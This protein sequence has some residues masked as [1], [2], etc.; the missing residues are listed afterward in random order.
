MSRELFGAMGALLDDRE[1][2]LT[3]A[4]IGAVHQRMD[5]GAGLDSLLA[6]KGSGFAERTTQEYGRIVEVPV[7]VHAL[8]AW[9]AQ[10]RTWQEKNGAP[11][12]WQQVRSQF[13]ALVSAADHL[14]FRID[15]AGVSDDSDA[16]RVD[17]PWLARTLGTP[18]LDAHGVC[19]AQPVPARTLEWS[20]P[21]RIAVPRE[22][23][24]SQFRAS[25]AGTP[26]HEL[27][28]PSTTRGA[29][30]CCCRWA[31]ATRCARWTQAMCARA[32]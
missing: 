10:S 4:A 18:A 17:L 27:Y 6:A 23:G 16:A 14:R 8:Q 19:V 13:E 21:L 12:P 3:L 20:W 22:A 31:F 28:E 9:I 29:T 5:A 32:R 11:M 2:A 24:G 1:L 15:L 30:S 25:L 26:Y 7:R